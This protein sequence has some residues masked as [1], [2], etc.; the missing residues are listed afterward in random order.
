MKSINFEFLRPCRPELVATGEMAEAYTYADPGSALVK[1]RNFA[2]LLVTNIYREMALP[3]PIKGNLND[4]LNETAFKTAIPPVIVSK[5]HSL[6]IQGNKAAHGDKVSSSTALWILE[7][8]YHLACWY[9][10][11]VCKGKQDL[12]PEFIAPEPQAPLSDEADLSAKE[13][14][15]ILEKLAAQEA[16][17]QQL[18]AELEATRKQAQIVEPTAAERE[19]IIEQAEQAVSELHF[20]EATTRQRLIDAALISAGWNVGLN[21]QSTEQ[22][23]QEVKILY[24]PTASGEGRADYVLYDEANKPFAVIEAKETAKDVNAGRTQARFYADGLEKQYGQRPVIFYTNGYEIY[25]WND[26]VKETPRMIHGFY[27]KD[28]LD[29]M[30][31][32]RNNRKNLLEM[33]PNPD[34]AGRMYQIEAIK[35][36]TERF[37]QGHRKAL[38]V[39]A[40]GTGKT[41]VAI[42]LCELLSRALWAK[43][44]LFLCDRRELRKQANNVFKEFLPGEPRTN[45]TALTAQDKDKRIYLATYPAMMKCFQSFDI[46]F[47]DLIIADESHRSIYNRYRDLFL[48][49]DCYQVGLTATPIK[50]KQLERNTYKLFGCEDKDPTAH[51]DYE[52][53]INHKP[54]FLVPFEVF[55]TTTEF[56]RR[57]IRY[58]QMSEEQRQQLEEDEENPSLIEYDAAEVDRVIFNKDTNRKILRNLMENGIR[59][60]S[61]M[62]PGKSII[63][64]RSHTH[65]KLLQELFDEMYPQYGGEFCQV[66]DNYDP[67]AE[68]LIDD[69]K[70]TGT[71]PNLTIAI[72]VDMLDTGIDIPEIVNLVFAKPVKSVVKFW[73]MIGR[74]TRLC[75]NLFGTGEDKKAFYIFDHWGN[76]EFFEEHY[77]EVEPSLQKSLLQRLFEARLQLAEASI[78]AGDAETFDAA[79]ALIAEDI[80]DL[81]SATISVKEKWRELQAVKQGE[82]LRSFSPQV[83]AILQNDIAPL[84]QWRNIEGHEPKFKFDLL[85]IGLQIERLRGSASFNNLKDELINEVAK[86]PVNLNA[87]RSRQ[88]FITQVRGNSFWKKVTN[89]SLEEVRKNLRGVMQYIN[90]LSFGVPRARVIDVAEDESKIEMIRH[91]PKLEGLQLAAYRHRVEQVLLTLMDN[92]PALQKIRRGQRV[93]PDDLQELCALVLA[94]DPEIDLYDLCFHYPEVADNLDLAIRGIIGLQPEAVNERFEEFVHRHPIL[95]AKQ[96]RF[97]SLL[98][99]HIAK[100]GSIELNRLYEAPFTSVDSNSI[101]GVFPDDGQNDEVLAIIAS[102]NSPYQK[103]DRV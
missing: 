85:M 27:S 73:Q 11:G 100:F 67:R 97:L 65:A 91:I 16:Q 94:Q 4:L 79:I 49:F 88:E 101:D 10:I 99:N 86:L 61:G 32:Q 76:F 41:R 54:P 93:N 31:F 26:A 80:A 92:S 57:G 77:K 103:V 8:A 37:N 95:S 7:E 53:A 75:P 102:F 15:E 30:L 50:Y 33:A 55:K 45:I 6:R 21:G 48:Y 69:L 47:F 39:Q 3:A 12:L 42:A 46:G 18:F 78:A 64:A 44:I 87:V 35:R 34:I 62:H 56:L 25:I 74:G 40:T 9:Y 5:L 29:Y 24:Q 58:S 23:G 1:L 66:I 90:A 38:I 59:D 52:E 84:M 71:N 14:K 72:S 36:V 60:A 2:E 70:G 13:R 89:A 68:Q 96:M 51:F 22:V 43:R 17:L 98:K 19:A 82:T 83:K 81:P 28:S 63:F 20:D